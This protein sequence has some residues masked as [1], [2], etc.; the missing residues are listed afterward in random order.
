M[1]KC[2][3]SEALMLSNNKIGHFVCKWFQLIWRRWIHWNHTVEMNMK[4]LAAKIKRQ[5]LV[6]VICFIYLLKSKWVGDLGGIFKPVEIVEVCL[7]FWK[8][9]DSLSGIALKLSAKLTPTC[10]GSLDCV[11]GCSSAATLLR[12]KRAATRR[13]TPIKT[14]SNPMHKRDQKRATK[15][16]ASCANGP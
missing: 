1:Y 8:A 16:V 14:S 5:N 9:F 7:L 2:I 15:S 13:P 10:D 3:G 11:G 12:I 4:W 6:E